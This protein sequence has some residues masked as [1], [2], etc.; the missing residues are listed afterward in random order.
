MTAGLS[1]RALRCMIAEKLPGRK[2][3]EDALLAL[4]A[5]MEQTANYILTRAAQAHD[6]ENI[7]RRQIGERPKVRLSVKHIKIALGAEPEQ[8]RDGHA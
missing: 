8:G 1:K 7:V 5:S 6:H 3:S 2:V 4:K